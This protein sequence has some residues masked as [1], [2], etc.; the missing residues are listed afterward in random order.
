MNYEQKAV[1]I[2]ETNSEFKVLDGITYYC[3]SVS[4]GGHLASVFLRAIADE[5]DRRNEEWCKQHE[6]LRIQS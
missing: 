3:P 4:R 2:T 5:I 6:H 1:Y